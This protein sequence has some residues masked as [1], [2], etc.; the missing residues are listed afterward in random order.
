MK[1]FT[2]SLKEDG[3]NRLISVLAKDRDMALDE[4][5]RQLSGPGRLH[6]WEAWVDN[7]SHLVDITDEIDF[8][9]KK[10]QAKDELIKKFDDYFGNPSGPVFNQHVNDAEKRTRLLMSVV[11]P[12]YLALVD[13]MAEKHNGIMGIFNEEPTIATAVYVALVNAFVLEV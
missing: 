4:V 11:F 2:A 7:G 13:A 10:D 9:P 3:T 5:H 6:I 1:K 12:T 8:I